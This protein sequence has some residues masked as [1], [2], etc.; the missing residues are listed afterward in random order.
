MDPS[1]VC[2]VFRSKRQVSTL[3][4]GFVSSTQDPAE[5]VWPQCSGWVYLTLLLVNIHPTKKRPNGQ[6]TTQLLPA[7]TIKDTKNKTIHRVQSHPQWGNPRQRC[8][9]L[10]GC[11]LATGSCVSFLGRSDGAG[12]VNGAVVIHPGKRHVQVSVQQEMVKWRG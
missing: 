2:K 11:R 12:Q 5:F 10:V 3:F 4:I 1:W 8:S 9:W 6:S 7:T